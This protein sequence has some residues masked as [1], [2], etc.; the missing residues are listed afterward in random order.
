MFDLDIHTRR[1]THDHE[2]DRNP[3]GV[4]P[5]VGHHTPPTRQLAMS[6]AAESFDTMTADPFRRSTNALA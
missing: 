5:Q 3:P 4:R 2:G 1:R 6:E